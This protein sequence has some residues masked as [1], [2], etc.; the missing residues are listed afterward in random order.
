V[1]KVSDI[2]A[3]RARLAPH[4]YH[5]FLQPDRPSGWLVIVRGPESRAPVTAR[6]ATRSEGLALAER[7]FLHHRLQQ[8]DAAIRER[9][10]TPP[11]WDGTQ[12]A[13]LAALAD[14]ARQHQIAA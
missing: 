10:L 6:A 13:H 12:E 7:L 2:A 5:L 1:A 14:F 4:G 3:L 11:P 8:L 9:G